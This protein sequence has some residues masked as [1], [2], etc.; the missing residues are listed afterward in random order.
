M[1]HVVISI[2]RQLLEG[3]SSLPSS[4]GSELYPGAVECHQSCDTGY[5]PDSLQEKWWGF[6]FFSV[7]FFFFPLQ[8]C[9]ALLHAC[10]S[11]QLRVRCRCHCP[12]PWLL[13]LCGQSSTAFPPGHT[14]WPHCLAS[15]SPKETAAFSFPIPFSSGVQTLLTS[16]LL[17]GD[18]LWHSVRC[19][20]AG[21]LPVQ[22]L[23]TL[24]FPLPFF[25]FCEDAATSLPC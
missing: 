12:A 21:Q 22:E 9:T 6:F 5:K 13:P 8:I 1:C 19:R 16:L 23:F 25:F 15:W 20:A 24:H 10:P 17:A 7:G 18:P 11:P 14:P 3:T 4:H 2:Q